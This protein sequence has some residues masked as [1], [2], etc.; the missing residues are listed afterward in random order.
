[1]MTDQSE[2]HLGTVITFFVIALVTMFTLIW[3]ERSLANE[4][5]YPLD[6]RSSASLRGIPSLIGVYILLGWGFSLVGMLVLIPGTTRGTTVVTFAVGGV[7]L[8][9]VLRLHALSRGFVLQRGGTGPPPLGDVALVLATLGLGAGL[10]ISGVGEVDAFVQE[11]TGFS[12]NGDHINGQAFTITIFLASI[13]VFIVVEAVWHVWSTTEGYKRV[14][15]RL[16]QASVDAVL[17]YRL[18]MPSLQ[19]YLK[20]S[21][22][23]MVVAPSE[24]ER[25]TK[26][27]FK[28]EPERVASLARDMREILVSSGLMIGVSSDAVRRHPHFFVQQRARAAQVIQAHGLTDDDVFAL[29]D[30]V[31]GE[32]RYDQLSI[33]LQL[34]FEKEGED[35]E[36]LLREIL[37]DAVDRL[38]RSARS[39]QEIDWARF[40]RQRYW[41]KMS[42]GQVAVGAK[43]A[44]ETMSKKFSTKIIPALRPRIVEVITNLR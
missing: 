14:V 6:R 42:V 8:A 25:T 35:G 23:P 43:T 39:S 38:E 24:F 28:D 40:L 30:V 18:G 29:L 27:M 2:L 20:V 7:V 41:D 33:T 31:H 21:R 12:R 11:A 26:Q 36:T 16:A 17:R 1:M 44:R 19:A 34:L 37:E 22:S 4:F 5:S 15:A 9:G 10:L 13:C 3:V 32:K